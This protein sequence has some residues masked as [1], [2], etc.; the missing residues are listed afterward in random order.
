MGEFHPVRDECSVEELD[1]L[2]LERDAAVA[3]LW[4]VKNGEWFAINTARNQMTVRVSLVGDCMSREDATCVSVKKA[5]ASREN[6]ITPDPLRAVA[7]V[8]ARE[9]FNQFQQ[10]GESVSQSRPEFLTIVE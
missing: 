8:V 9:V 2:R 6:L 7:L 5:T 3:V 1:S 10:P 4:S